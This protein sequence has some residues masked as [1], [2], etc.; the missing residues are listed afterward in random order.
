MSFVHCLALTL[1][2]KPEMSGLFCLGERYN[3]VRDLARSN[4]LPSL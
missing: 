2:C 3:R 4:E 1:L